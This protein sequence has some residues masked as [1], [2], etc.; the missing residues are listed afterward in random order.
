MTSLREQRRTQYLWWISTGFVASLVA[1]AGAYVWL[2]ARRQAEDLD[3]LTSVGKAASEGLERAFERAEAF[4]ETSAAFM[5]AVGADLTPGEFALFVETLME[6]EDDVRSFLWLPVVDHADRQAFEARASELYGRPIQIEEPGE[7]QDVRASDRDRYHPILYAA[8]LNDADIGFDTGFGPERRAF[9]RRAM[10]L[11]GAYLTPKFRLTRERNGGEAVAFLHPVRSASTDAVAGFIVLTIPLRS[12]VLNWFANMADQDIHVEVFDP[13]DDVA[14][15]LLFRGGPEFDPDL[16]VRKVYPIHLGNRTWEARFT[17]PVGFGGGGSEAGVGA[18]A[19]VVVGWLGSLI[20]VAIRRIQRLREDVQKALKLGQYE[21][22]KKLGEGAMGVVLLARHAM[23]KRPTALKLMLRQNESSIS[24]FEREV[25]L[26]AGLNHPNIVSVFDYG[27]TE[28]GIFY[29][30]MEYLPGI[31]LQKLEEEEGPL[32]D[33]R[34]VF[35]LRQLARGLL[36]AHVAGLVHRDVKPANLILTQ[37]GTRSDLL[38]ILDFGL[39][40]PIDEVDPAERGKVSGT[41]LYMAPEALATPDDVGPPADVYAFGCVA[42]FLVSGRPPIVGPTVKEILHR[43]MHQEPQSIS[44]QAAVPVTPQFANLVMRCLEKNPGNRPT[45]Q[46]LVHLLDEMP[47]HEAWTEW[48]AAAWWA[49]RG[50]KLRQKVQ[51][52]EEASFDSVTIQRQRS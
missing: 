15:P 52:L 10:T 26:S 50:S 24:R 20:L 41:P 28:D 30:A 38:K 48:S 46:E 25:R 6:P 39:A 1:G 43:Q 9:F 21:V 29:Y 37:I 22:E 40:K 8:P 31:D 7:V 34:A 5:R 14:D 51:T 42:Y 17:A 35:L 32:S 12:I 45:T 18:A 47:V 11:E 13:S 19:V 4:L 44:A 2:D 36:E 3:E 23:I 49:E 27:R 33:G 16:T